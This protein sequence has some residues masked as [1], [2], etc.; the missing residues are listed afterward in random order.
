M[1]MFLRSWKDA[2][3]AMLTILLAISWAIK[4]SE[5][6][7][8]DKR[9]ARAAEEAEAH[10]QTQ[11]AFRQ[12]RKIAKAEDAMHAARVERDQWKISREVQTDY[13]KKLIDLRNRYDALRLREQAPANSGSGGSPTMPGIP[14]TPRRTD[15]TALKDGFLASE[16]ALRLKGLQ[17]WVRGQ[18]SVP[19]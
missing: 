11:A 16:I 15:D 17:D 13:A 4:S 9:G 1:T 18:Q 5:T 3:I 8:A 19:R 7:R 14:D 6:R 2:A 10:R 12:A